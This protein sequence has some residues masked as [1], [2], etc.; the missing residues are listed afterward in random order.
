M[1]GKGREVRLADGWWPEVIRHQTFYCR[2]G[3]SLGNTSQERQENG[4]IVMMVQ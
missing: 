4:L 2:I 1:D 3:R